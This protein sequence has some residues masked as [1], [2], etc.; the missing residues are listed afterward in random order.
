MTGVGSPMPMDQITDIELKNERSLNTLVRA[1]TLSQNQFALIVV[2]CNYAQLRDRITEQL[3]EHLPIPV[4][5]L[6]LPESAKTLYTTIHMAIA[7]RTQGAEGKEGE[8]DRCQE[9]EV[10]SQPSSIPN[11]QSSPFPSALM[12]FGLETLHDLDQA[13]IATN[14]VREELRKQFSFPLVLW[15][16]DDVLWKLDRLAPD[17]FSW[18]GNAIVE[19]EMAI[20][21]LVRSLKHHSDRLFNSILSMGD[22]QFWAIW[23]IHP[24]NA[25]RPNELTFA[26]NDL[27]SNQYAI[28]DELQASLDFLLGQNA[29]SQGE[30]ET[31]HELY[32]RSLTFWLQHM[33]EAKEPRA[34]E[35][36]EDGGDGKIRSQES[37]VRS[38]KDLQDRPI[39]SDPSPIS[40]SP[41][42]PSASS[43]SPTLPSPLPPIPYLERAACLLFY[44][45]LWWRSYAILQRAA[46]RS[47]CQQSRYYFQRSLD[48]FTQENRQDLVARF[49]IAQAETLQKLEQWDELDTLAK[50]AL[51]LHKLYKDPVRQARDR[52]FLA[53]VAIARSNWED[54]KQQVETALEILDVAEAELHAVDHLPDPHLENS[55]ELAHRYHYGWYLFLRAKAEKQLGNLDCAIHALESARDRSHPSNDPFLYIQILRQLRDNY[56]EKGEY[57]LAFRTRQARRLIEHQYGYRA[58]VGALRL[59]PQEVSAGAPLPLPAQIDQQRLLAQELKASGR[60]KDLNELIARLSQAQ[61]K[62]IVIHGPSGVG[63]SS[64]L[65]AGLLPLLQDQTFE[66]RLPFPLLVDFYGDWQSG[67]QKGLKSL[68]LESSEQ[69]SSLPLFSPSSPLSAPLFQTLINQLKTATERNVLPILL[70]DQ[71]EEFFFT[72]NTVQERIPFYRFLGECL[73]LPFVKVVLS[74]RE[75]YLHYLLEFQRYANLDIINNDILGKQIRYPLGDLTLA[76]AKAVIKSLTE[77]AQFYLPDD[78]VDALVHDLAGELGEVRPIE[79]QVVGAQL[80]AEGIDTLAKYQQKGP[81]E[82]LVQR[83]LE[84]VVKDCGPENEDLARIVLFLLTNEKGARPLK[85]REDLEA[86][87]VDL[88]LTHAIANLDLV[89]EVLVGSG[90]VFLIPDF[91]AD[92]Y[93]L[94]HD[95]LVSFIRHDQESEVAQL[96]AELQR[97]R[98]QRRVA[99]KELQRSEEKLHQI[100]QTTR[101]ILRQGIAGFAMIAILSGGIVAWT[102]YTAQ[103]ARETAQKA[104]TQAEIA[105]SLLESGICI[106]V[107]PLENSNLNYQ[108][109][110]R[111]TVAIPVNNHAQTATGMLNEIQQVEPR[112]S[113]TRAAPGTFITIGQFDTLEAAFPVVEHLKQKGF[114][115]IVVPRVQ[116]TEREN[117]NNP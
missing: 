116:V 15:A 14:L 113:L 88:G 104:A 10:R 68:G 55:L 65:N 19:F 75:D 76:D 100:E 114:D 95:Y 69:I 3:Q 4:Q 24:P 99:E 41:P 74:L 62:L 111:Y 72:Y 21:E 18:A 50:Q 30:M 28:D 2:R 96:E 98:E 42:L 105:R 20:P 5:V 31:A 63:K 81:K 49:I 109:T 52:G 91:P 12:I 40:A 115:A 58:F 54:A 102:S 22:E 82:K 83:S 45:G 56:F 7:E 71:F 117:A 26:I 101:R 97:E 48:L 38:Q 80:Q 73:K 77:K 32:Q 34:E 29:H 60:E 13:L 25:L 67:L 8:G 36:W 33:Q 90:L 44:L 6:T 11:L 23:Q 16:N 86:D 106:T 39:S 9:S 108:C 53:E 46:Y 110:Y 92:C 112:A 43:L 78:L 35:S 66:S 93:Q 57:Q 17:L 103:K 1:I 51:V 94:V 85:T 107:P 27:Q 70:F 47:A 87:L 61:Y 79:L 84:D 89:L 37:E 64:I 59:Q